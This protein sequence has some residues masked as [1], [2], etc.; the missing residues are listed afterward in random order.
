MRRK[1]FRL[2][3]VEGTQQITEPDFSNINVGRDKRLGVNQDIYNIVGGIVSAF[4]PGLGETIKD[5]IGKN[6][7]ETRIM[8]SKKTRNERQE[9]IQTAIQ[10]A[11]FQDATNSISTYDPSSQPIAEHGTA[12]NEEKEI[13]AEKDELVFRKYGSRYKL[14]MDLNG[15]KTHKAGGEDITVQAGDVIFPGSKREKLIRMLDYNGFVSKEKE[16]SFET[17]RVKLPADEGYEK[18]KGSIYIKPSK[19]GTFKAAAKKHDKSVQ[20]FASQVLANKENYSSGMVKKANFAKN[21][22][23]WKHKSKAR[24]GLAVRPEEPEV[25]DSSTNRGAN[26]NWQDVAASAATLAPVIYNTIRGSKKPEPLRRHFVTPERIG[27]VDT[28]QIAKNEAEKL[29]RTEKRNIVNLSGGNTGVAL[30][31]IG[32]AGN[33]LS[34]NFQKIEA[35]RQSQLQNVENFNAQLRGEANKINTNLAIDFDT[36]ESQNKAARNAFLGEATSQVSDIAQRSQINRRLS[37]RDEKLNRLEGLK[38]LFTGT[39]NYRISP[40]DRK[41]IMEGRYEDVSPEGIQFIDNRFQLGDKIGEKSIVEEPRV[42]QGQFK[43]TPRQKR[44]FSL[45]KNG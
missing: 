19:I 18:Q 5:G 4:I 21:A 45:Q 26:I 43:Y 42:D 3:Y 7:G 25:A 1:K 27:F 16:P 41:A 15:S 17:E 8:K 23:K 31:N 28:S 44:S 22:S 39:A 34:E 29:Y 14:V 24:R 33:R 12:I 36:M 6:L 37:A 2:K 30:S 11:K 10:D 40:E 38:L 32:V 9:G 35:E 13:E 20:G